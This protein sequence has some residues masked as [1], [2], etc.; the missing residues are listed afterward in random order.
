M[1]SFSTKINAQAF[2]IGILCMQILSVSSARNLQEALH[3]PLKASLY[4]SPSLMDPG[5]V[6]L[7]SSMKS[8]GGVQHE[9]LEGKYPNTSPGN[10]NP[11]GHHETS[12]GDV[13]KLP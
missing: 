4:S 13:G 7:S 8:S 9:F 3:P 1:A 11:I 12:P 6:Q 5:Q 2:I 10:S